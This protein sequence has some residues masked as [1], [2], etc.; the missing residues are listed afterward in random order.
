MQ[1]QL[2]SGPSQ[3]GG[4]GGGCIAFRRS[5]G[6]GAYI[7][8]RIHLQHA[9]PNGN[10]KLGIKAIFEGF[11]RSFYHVFFYSLLTMENSI[12]KNAQKHSQQSSKS[13]ESIVSQ[14]TL[15]CAAMT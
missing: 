4:A 14:I 11:D 12:N 6:G 10:D 1:L 7:H 13:I 3:V 9:T 5:W 2:A 15:I 8:P